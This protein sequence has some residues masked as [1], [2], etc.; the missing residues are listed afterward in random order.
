MENAAD[1]GQAQGGREKTPPFC[2]AAICGIKVYLG[3]KIIKFGQGSEVR[4]QV[5]SLLGVY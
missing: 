1:A 2:L 3:F 4:N 5:L